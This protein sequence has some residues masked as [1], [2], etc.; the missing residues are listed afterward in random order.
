MGKVALMDQSRIA[1]LGNIHAAEALYRAG[2]HPA[3]KPTSLTRP[4]WHKLA[5]GIQQTIAYALSNEAGEELE[6]I[7]EPG[8]INPFLIYGRAGERCTR[9]QARI[10]SFIQQGRTT[11]YCPQCQPRKGA[12]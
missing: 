11:H 1:G 7:E 12:R 10:R 4:E 9:C 2:L 3:R 6:Y 8:A 5:R